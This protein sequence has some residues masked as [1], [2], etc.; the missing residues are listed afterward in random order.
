[1]K[2]IDLPPIWLLGC[3]IVSWIF[4]VVIGALH[5]PWLGAILLIL[6]VLLTLAAVLEFVRARTTVIPRRAPTA[7]I[8]SGVFRLSRNP[9]YLA[10]VLF[11]AGL[12]FWFG[13]LTGLVLVPVLAV[14]LQR[15]FILNE[16]DRL[17]A[18]FGEAFVAY[19]NQTRRWI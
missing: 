17:E 5:I 18:E 6:A 12:S 7:L 15:R 16:E 11:L 1:M 3:L 14:I 10:D 13:N 9:I 19:R 2:W 4:P 8:S